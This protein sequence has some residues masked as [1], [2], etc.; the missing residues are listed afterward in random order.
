MVPKQ[1]LSR[2][3]GDCDVHSNHLVEYKVVEGVKDLLLVAQ[4]RRLE[5]KSAALVA[6]EAAHVDLSISART[7]YEYCT[8]RIHRYAP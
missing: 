3:D 1:Y 2:Y 5:H 4:H 6:V 8:I 7:R